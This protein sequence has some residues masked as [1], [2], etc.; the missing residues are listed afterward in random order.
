MVSTT[1]DICEVVGS[2][3]GILTLEESARNIY[4]SYDLFSYGRLPKVGKDTEEVLQF[5]CSLMIT[6]LFYLSILLL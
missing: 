1:P 4:S 3:L 5:Q 6:S 2:E